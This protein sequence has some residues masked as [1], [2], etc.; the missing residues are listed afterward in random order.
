M[1]FFAIK[2]KIF[3]Q[4]YTDFNFNLKIVNIW[5]SIELFKCCRKQI[6][7]SDDI[8]NMNPDEI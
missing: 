2:A 3:I 1:I 4:E 7:E 5:P 6:D 8:V